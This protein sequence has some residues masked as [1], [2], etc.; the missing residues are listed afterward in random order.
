MTT[1]QDC[2]N[3]NCPCAGPTDPGPDHRCPSE[4]LSELERIER[5]EARSYRPYEEDEGLPLDS[6][7]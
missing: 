2:L 6:L 4:G 3:G 1:Y 7:A 5:D